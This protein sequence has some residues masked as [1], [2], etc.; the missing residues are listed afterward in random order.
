M[1][2]VTDPAS[3]ILDA[4]CKHSVR[5]REERLLFNIG[6]YLCLY[7]IILFYIQ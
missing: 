5:F 3:Q 1:T 7:N 6:F 4:I 2:P